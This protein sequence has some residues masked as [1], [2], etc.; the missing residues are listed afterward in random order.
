MYLFKGDAPVREFAS[1]MREPIRTGVKLVGSRF[2]REYPYQDGYLLD[3][4]RQIRAAVDL[5][6]VL[7]GGVTNRQI[8]D[9]AMREGFQFVAMGRALL[10]EPD[11]INRIAADSGTRSL[12]NHNNR[13][14]VTIF[15][16]SRCVLTPENPPQP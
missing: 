4:A 14:M 11:L 3:D 15:T 7:L 8:M 9:T 16:G 10:R 12:C 1:V 13:C 5:P 6:M 2:L